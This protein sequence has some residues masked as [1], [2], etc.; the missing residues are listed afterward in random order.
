MVDF[1]S[2][3]HQVIAGIFQKYIDNHNLMTFEKFLEFAK[4]HDIFPH[5]SSKGSLYN[6]FH[7]LSKIKDS[8]NPT[9]SITKFRRELS[10]LDISSMSPR[11]LERMNS[12]S[13]IHKID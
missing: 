12:Q 7:Q 4:D 3:L 2:D 9:E 13:R 10:D 1:M 6:I 11:G 5:E 8:L